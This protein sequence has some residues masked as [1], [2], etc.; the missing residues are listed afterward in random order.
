MQD[1]IA[2]LTAKD[3][4]AAYEYAKQIGAE[5][6]ESDK[7]L[8][9]ISIFA[10]L[11]VHKSS[12]VRTRGFVLICNQSRWAVDSQLE[13]VFPQMMPL[14]N[15]PK[16]TVVRQCLAALHEVVL[17]RPEMVRK[18]ENA[19]DEI[20]LAKYKDSM[21]PLIQKDIDALKKIMG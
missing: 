16:P 10:D 6:A 14:L 4:K 13:E 5:S 12:F 7:Y 21:T 19:V 3:D 9:M 8:S 15:D 2:R 18:I 20:D 1:I 11:L 17:F